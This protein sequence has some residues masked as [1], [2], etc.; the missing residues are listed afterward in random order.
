MG[1]DFPKCPKCGSRKTIP[2]VYG[3]ATMWHLEME[4][5]D[6]IK[7]GDKEIKS[8]SPKW[9]CKKCKNEWGSI[10]DLNS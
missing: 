9:H 2:I 3:K 1:E 4:I 10:K 7:I 6:E 5:K 8:D